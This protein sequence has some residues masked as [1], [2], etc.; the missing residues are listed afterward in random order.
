MTC[1]PDF[2]NRRSLTSEVSHA[3]LGL[4]KSPVPDFRSLARPSRTS[5]VSP[6]PSV[7]GPIKTSEVL[8]GLSTLY[9]VF[10]SS[11][12][13]LPR[14]DS[15]VQ[16][17]AAEPQR[18]NQSGSPRLRDSALALSPRSLSLDLGGTF[19]NS[20]LRQ[21]VLDRLRVIPAEEGVGHHVVAARFATLG[22]L[23][24]VVHRVVTH[25]A[26]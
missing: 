3:R 16:R 6:E 18:Q 26:R 9:R 10:Q 12:T 24:G 13:P 7:A 22:D 15:N 14:A 2:R 8:Q 23:E 25:G 5:E 4:P 11:A 1:I 21:I 17:K 19:S 20:I